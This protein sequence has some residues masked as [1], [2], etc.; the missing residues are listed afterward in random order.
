[1]NTTS[2]YTLMTATR[3]QV[4]GD[5]RGGTSSGTDATL[6]TPAESNAARAAAFDLFAR[7]NELPPFAA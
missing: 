6:A 1:M 2:V 5:R 3:F 7:D 4:K